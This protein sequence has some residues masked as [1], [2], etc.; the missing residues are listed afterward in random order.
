MSADIIQAKY[1]ELENIARCFT[2]QAESQTALTRRLEQN[3]QALRQGGWVGQG[4]NAFFAEM[5]GKIFPTMQRLVSALEQAQTVTL[6]VKEVI[7]QAEEE[8]AEPF[9]GGGNTLDITTKNGASISGE[10]GASIKNNN[11]SFNWWNFTGSAVDATS[12]ILEKAQKIPYEDYQSIGRLINNVIGNKKGGWVDKMDELGHQI[13][14]TEGKRLGS[15]LDG[16]SILAGIGGDLSDGY[17]LDKAIITSVAEY[18]AGKLLEFGTE[19]LVTMGLTKLGGKALYAVPYV[20]EVMM[21]YDGAIIVGNLAAG[22]LEL[23]GFHDQAKWLQ[24]TVDKVDINQYIGKGLDKAY[25]Y[26]APGVKDFAGNALDKGKDLAEDAYHE[27]TK[28]AGNALD[29][30]TDLAKEGAKWV[31]KYNPF[32]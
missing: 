27:S 30:G 14:G 24:N 16:L 17:G 32:K 25:D 8:A 2:A 20:G 29:K 23:A 10:V 15:A 11:K 13:R 22:G 7:Q 6:Q 3:V 1:D 9:K 19:K 28:L 5:D 4:A 21:V 18:G 31:N 26:V 12:K